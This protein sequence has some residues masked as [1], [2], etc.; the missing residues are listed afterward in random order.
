MLGQRFASYEEIFMKFIPP[1]GLGT[2]GLK[3]QVAIDSVRTGLEL[4][5]RHFDTAQIY[6]NEA[7]VGQALADSGVAVTSCSSPPRSGPITSA[8]A[9]LS[10]ACVRACSGWAWS[11][12][13]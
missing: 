4:G 3:D 11:G 8:V 5:C 13:T 10:P 7:A 9:K 12:S 2:F 6:G 1:F